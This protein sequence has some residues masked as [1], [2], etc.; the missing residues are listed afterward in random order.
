MSDS[1]VAR[2]SYKRGLYDVRLTDSLATV[3]AT[4]AGYT[5]VS[6]EF[7]RL[8]HQGKVLQ[9]DDKT[10]ESLGIRAGTKLLMTGSTAA[11]VEQVQTTKVNSAPFERP[12]A[13]APAARSTRLATPSK[14]T[15]HNIHPL[16]H[17]PSPE[18]ARKLLERLRD[19]R[20]IVAIMNH[21]KWSVGSL[22]ELSPAEKTIL[23]YNRN[24]GAVI[25]LR[26]RTND[27]DGFRPYDSI[28]KV[29]L[30]ELSHMRWSE[31]DENFHALNRQLNKDV[32]SMDWAAQGGRA[33]SAQVYYNPQEEEEV[34]A[35]RFEGGVFRLGGSSSGTAGNV[36]VLSRREL[37]AQAALLR[38]SKEEQEMVDGCGG[39]HRPPPS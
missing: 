26:L 10:L 11:A 28:R 39:D 30:H 21:Y 22:I 23:G 32:V 9:E 12:R 15:F 5:G 35:Q 14:Y 8:I 25:A 2:V 1:P 24:K 31:H 34:E 36:E 6:V 18:S 29:L 17:F 7:Q 33:L 13:K 16:E 37:L 3:K 20:G 4:L 38:L 19:D 27:L